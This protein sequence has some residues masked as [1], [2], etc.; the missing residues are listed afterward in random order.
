[1]TTDDLLKQGIAALKDGRKAQAHSLLTQVVQQD[2]QN[3]M[4]WLWLSGAVDTD[5]D[6]RICLENVLAIDPNNGVA[7]RGLESLIAK[8]GV[9]PLKSVS[10]PTPRAEPAATPREQPAQPL[11][12]ASAPDITQRKKRK[13]SPKRKKMTRQQTRLLIALGAGVLVVACTTLAGIWWVVDSGL[14]QLAP[15]V[16]VAV[17]I[18][19]V[20]SV[21]GA[22]S[23]SGPTPTSEETP[24]PVGH[25]ARV[26]DPNFPIETA[27]TI[28]EVR[29]GRAA[30]AL[31]RTWCL[32]HLHEQQEVVAVR[33]R[34]DYLSGPANRMMLFNDFSFQAVHLDGSTPD[35]CGS[36][37]WSDP[38]DGFRFESYS[39][40]TGE[41]WIAFKIR[42]GG[43]LPY[44]LYQ[45]LII[46]ASDYEGT[47]DPV[48]LQLE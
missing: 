18:T 42:R 41:G 40:S 27:V 30:Q 5:E 15:V 13:A 10:P 19:Q 7:K 24:V 9:R 17:A 31:F 11:A 12:K 48:I 21:A 45:H 23:T 33:L 4:A 35:S 29:R 47:L 8:E 34:V 2:D 36:S 28:L 6:R 1:M 44:L 46:Y 20:P 14:L 26:R 37:C 32:D 43:Q 25:T 16:P 22:I 38:E 3:E 39:P